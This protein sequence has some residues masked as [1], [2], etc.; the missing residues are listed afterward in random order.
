MT[1]TPSGVPKAIG[2]SLAND[3]EDGRG[4]SLIRLIRRTGRK[5]SFEV[6]DLP[7]LFTGVE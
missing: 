4:A 3:V 7:S 5:V 1:C 6:V 2:D